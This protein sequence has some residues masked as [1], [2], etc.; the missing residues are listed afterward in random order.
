M[1]IVKNIRVWLLLGIF[2]VTLAMLFGGQAL[3]LK[4]RVNDPLKHDIYAIK[5]VRMYRAVQDKDG[6]KVNLKLAQVKDLQQVL[7]QV[8]RKLEYYFN[9]PVQAIEIEDHSDQR[10]REARYQLSFNLEEAVVAGHY[11]QL[12]EAL[13]LDTRVHS[14]LYFSPGFIYIQ[15][16]DGHYYHYEAYPRQVNVNETGTANGGGTV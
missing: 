4:L 5:G 9:K 7:D 3:T 12:K 15:L 13:N 10:L 14:R 2:S 11:I 1:K 16:E 8:Q 6:V